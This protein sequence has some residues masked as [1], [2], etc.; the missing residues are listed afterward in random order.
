[1]HS[2]NDKI[3]TG[4][5]VDLYKTTVARRIHDGEEYTRNFFALLMNDDSGLVLLTSRDCE[6][7][8]VIGSSGEDSL[9]QKYYLMLQSGLLV[10]VFADDIYRIRIQAHGNKKEV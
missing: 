10:V 6:L 4:D 8:V 5:V 7:A 1:M 3:V 9:E 2:D